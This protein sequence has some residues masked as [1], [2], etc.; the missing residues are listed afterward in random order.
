MANP[1]RRSR[2]KVNAGRPSEKNTAKR[3]GG[4]LTPASGAVEG[5]KGDIVLD[6]FLV[7]AKSTIK[8]SISLK[9]DWLL[10]I[11]GEARKVG[12]TPA[13]AITFTTGN[14]RPVH[15]GR[16]VIIREDDFKE[17]IDGDKLGL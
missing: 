3:L 1:F 8:N 4:R 6:D 10:K 7:E 16:Y 17:L 5:A 15:N 14:G 12:K 13:L 9:L 11:T 2:P